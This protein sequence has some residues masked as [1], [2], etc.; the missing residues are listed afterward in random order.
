MLTI[1]IDDSGTAPD[2][3]I[4]IAAGWIADMAVWK[5][6]DQDWAEV[7]KDKDHEFNCMHMADFVYGDKDFVGWDLPKKWAVLKKLV[8]IVKNRAA[9]GFGLGVVKKDFDEVVPSEMRTLGYENHYTYAVRRVLG[10]I[11]DWRKVLK[12]QHRPIDYIFDFME[13]RD[14]RRKEIE[15]VFTTIGTPE[16]NLAMYG[17]REGGFRFLRKDEVPALQAA[18]M[19]AWTVYRALQVEIGEK[20]AHEFVP[21][22]FNE[23]HNYKN[24]QFL[25]GGWNK[26]QHLIDWVRGKGFSPSV[27]S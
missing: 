3:N 17:L 5:L 26:R 6:L 21:Y 10:M 14:M 19:F 23:F 12:I 2:Q 13:T 11:H 18:D 9:K 7:R 22:I 8:P 16:E 25:E 24:R 15:K 20:S 27:Q 1:Y 4:A